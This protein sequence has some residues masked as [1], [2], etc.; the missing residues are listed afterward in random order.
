MHEVIR[1]DKCVH[2]LVIASVVK[3]LVSNDIIYSKD[4]LTVLSMKSAFSRLGGAGLGLLS[5]PNWFTGCTT[6]NMARSSLYAVFAAS[7][8]STAGWVAVDCEP[9][10]S[11]TSS[12]F[13]ADA[14]AFDAQTASVLEGL[15][16]SFLTPEYR[17]NTFFIY[18]KRLRVHSPPEKVF[19]YFSSVKSNGGTFMTSLDLMRAAV[20]VFQPINSTH[21]RSGSLGG[22]NQED[23]SRDA[24]RLGSSK[25]SSFFKL[26]DTDGDGLISFPEYLFFITLLSLPVDQVKATFQQF[27]VDNSGTL[28]RDEFI[29]MMKVM[30]KSTSR[31]NASGFRTGLKVTS[32]DEIS[33]GL[34]EYLFEDA[35]QERSLS[36][37][38]FETF[39]HELRT[40]IDNLEFLHYDMMNVGTIGIKD[41]GYSVVAGANV[42][43]M[44][45]FIERISK[46]ASSDI[47]TSGNTISREEFMS[48]CRLLKH[49][50]TS[51][52]T[53]IQNHTKDGGKLD[54]PHFLKLAK[55]CGDNLTD[56]QVQII[57]FIFDVDGDG[58]LSPAEFL[59]VVCRRV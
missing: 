3:L 29:E 17:R 12:I 5:A 19:E 43:R 51:F 22:E 49:G 39:L 55:D 52:Q 58:E 13:T 9:T 57:F 56:V 8:A 59:D 21:V 38:Q 24:L 2:R 25:Q 45:Y 15:K 41:F 30:R 26:F 44:Q 33:M 11:D 53:K 46:L 27:D 10:R 16:F 4:I 18:E 1:A 7:V 14:V 48:F 20:P 6:M 28:T 47:G 32:M 35:G 42:K 34:V 40:E 50:D 37:D 36:L 54:K 31:G 23:D